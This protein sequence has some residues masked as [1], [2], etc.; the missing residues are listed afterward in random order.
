MHVGVHRAG[1]ITRTQAPVVLQLLESYKTM[2]KSIIPKRNA[3]T[4]LI[5]ALWPAAGN[6]GRYGMVYLMFL[7]VL[8]L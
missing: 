5:G 1:P 4:S 7:S 8:K 2:L 3:S 6:L